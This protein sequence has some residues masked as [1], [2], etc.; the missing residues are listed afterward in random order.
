MNVLVLILVFVLLVSALAAVLAKRF[1]ASIAILSVSTLALAGL[2]ALLRAPDV[3]I[4]EA[5]V[6]TGLSGVLLAL[7]ARRIGLWHSVDDGGKS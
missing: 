2:F 3:A 5:V 1:L 6:G 4:A 7:A